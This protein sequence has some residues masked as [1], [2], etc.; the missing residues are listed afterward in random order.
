MKAYRG[1]PPDKNAGWELIAECEDGGIEWNVYQRGQDHTP[2]WS[3]YKIVANGRVPAKANYWLARNDKTGQIGFSR[4]YVFMR[5]NRPKLHAQIEELFA[6]I[7]EK[8]SR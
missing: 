8:G 6:W 3:T 7:T 4:D 5:E 1:N 2:D